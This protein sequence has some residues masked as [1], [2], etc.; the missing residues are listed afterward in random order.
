MKRT[1]SKLEM[2]YVFKDRKNCNL[3]TRNQFGDGSL[4]IE[5]LYQA[6]KQR[7]EKEYEK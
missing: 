5:T 4:C 1:L 7:L 3:M 2:D 6:F